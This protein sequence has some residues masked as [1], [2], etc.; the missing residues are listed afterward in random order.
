MKE[1][2][3]IASWD[4]SG[5]ECIVD[6]TSWERNSLLNVIAGKELTPAPVSLR[7]LTM[8]ARY[9]PQRS[10]EIWSFTTVDAITETELKE[11]ARDNPQQ[12]VDL[13]RERGNCLYNSPKQ[14]VVIE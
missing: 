1:R 7:A 4:C 5:F 12:L 10:P 3:F 11:L 2:T 9:N 14:K 6:C 8:R 13:I